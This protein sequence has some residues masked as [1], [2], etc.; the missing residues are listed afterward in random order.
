V[1]AN[2]DAHKRVSYDMLG[3][4]QNPPKFVKNFLTNGNI[5]SATND[6]I[7]AV[8]RQTFPTD[9]HSY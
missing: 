9:K 2:Q 1:V 4:T 6:F 8:K 5:A 7:Q 3:I